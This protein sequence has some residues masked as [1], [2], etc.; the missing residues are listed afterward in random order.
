MTDGEQ[1]AP[2]PK[3]IG[4]AAQV[5]GTP[6][7]ARPGP[8][9][10]IPEKD[11]PIFDPAEIMERDAQRNASAFEVAMAHLGEGDAEKGAEKMGI[12]PEHFRTYQTVSQQIGEKVLLSPEDEAIIVSE[13]EK[14]TTST[15]PMRREYLNGMIDSFHPQLDEETKERVLEYVPPMTEEEKGG[16]KKIFPIDHAQALV[17]AEDTAGAAEAMGIPEEQFK[18]FQSVSEEI[19]K[20]PEQINEESIIRALK[21]SDESDTPMRRERLEEFLDAYHPELD[22][23]VKQRL[24]ESVKPMTED[25]KAKDHELK[26]KDKT[27]VNAEEIQTGIKGI[28]DELEATL[29]DP[30]LNLTPQERAKIAAVQ[31]RS[32]SLSARITGLFQ[33]GETGRVWAKRIG[34]GFYY[35]FLAAF[36]LILLEMNA[37][38]R[39]AGRQGNR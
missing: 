6:D 13:L 22:K 9:T 28:T 7:A 26:D 30:N 36:I 23:T 31:K 34:K 33:E 3:D 12:Y 35:A 32:N 24:L 16:D 15:I 29:T 39:M 20:D 8:G 19:L 38:H 1:Q 17:E 5:P 10:P 18:T 25:D 11:A 14:A 21:Q 27:P 37:I 2:G 4:R